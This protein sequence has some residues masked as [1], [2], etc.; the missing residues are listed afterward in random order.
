MNIKDKVWRVAPVALVLLY[1]LIT[2][3]L[4]TQILQAFSF[5]KVTISL[6]G[7]HGEVLIHLPHK[8]GTYTVEVP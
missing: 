7:E 4:V 8:S 1:L 2:V 3:N 5:V 6:P